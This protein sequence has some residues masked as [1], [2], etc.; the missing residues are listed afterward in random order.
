MVAL[1][2]GVLQAVSPT[3]SSAQSSATSLYISDVS[4]VDPDRAKIRPRMNVL[5]TGDRIVSVSS[6]EARPP[7][8][9]RLIDGTGL[10]LLPGLIDLHV[11]Q[12]SNPLDPGRGRLEAALA[13]AGVTSVRLACFECGRLDLLSSAPQKAAGGERTFGSLGVRVVARGT[14]P[15][16]HFRA[17]GVYR[18]DPEP[19]YRNWS[20]GRYT[21]LKMFDSTPEDILAEALGR[22]VRVEGHVPDGVAVREALELGQITFDHIYDILDECL[23]GGRSAREGALAT[24]APTT[25]AI[26]T[27]ACS[28]LARSIKTRGAAVIPTLVLLKYRASSGVLDL[29]DARMVDL[30][31]T[32]RRFWISE[33]AAT[34]TEAKIRGER[35]VLRAALAVV[36]ILRNNDVRVLA[37][38]DTPFPF[39]V[40]GSS[41]HEELELLHQ[42]GLTPAECLQAGTT[43]AARHYGVDDVIGKIEPGYFADFVLLRSNPLSDIENL[44]DIIGVAQSGRYQTIR[45]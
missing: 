21:F 45:N 3:P 25:L 39:S 32:E 5:V 15:F 35:A 23:V 13:R 14:T 41:L 43:A 28:R 7:T 4:I 29:I 36:R 8:E 42:A 30:P 26:D 16:S 11:H 1:V 31:N 33:A 12:G 44:R 34:R 27:V 24:R 22:G 17:A 40:P 18:H 2:L 19:F 38:S 10:F 6:G 37:G 20:A 9:A